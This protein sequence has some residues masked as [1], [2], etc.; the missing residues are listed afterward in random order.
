[1]G[2]D[3]PRCPGGVRRRRH[4][5][6]MRQAGNRPDRAAQDPQHPDQLLRCTMTTALAH[7]Q[8]TPAAVIQPASESSTILQVIQRAAADPQCD[9]EKMERLMSMHE[10]FLAKQ[11]EQQYAEALAMMQQELPVIT[12]RGGIKDKG[13]RIQSTYALWEDINEAIKPILAKHG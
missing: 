12:E 6:R 5:G 4:D 13:G 8:D 9:I 2:R 3:Q 1:Q 11:A 7:R 10:R